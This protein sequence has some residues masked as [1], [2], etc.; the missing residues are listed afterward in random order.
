[1]PHPRTNIVTLPPPPPLPLSIS[2]TSAAMTLA[3]DPPE[4]SSSSS[5]AQPEV[6]SPE[7]NE[8]ERV[9]DDRAS[10]Q[11]DTDDDGSDRLVKKV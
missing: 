2:L 6:G 8:G 11:P 4:E 9:S 5:A 10:A 1:M 3:P 7:G